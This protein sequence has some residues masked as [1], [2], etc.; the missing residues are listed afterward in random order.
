MKLKIVLTA[1]LSASLLACNKNELK[2][3]H[4]KSMDS[5]KE[6]LKNLKVINTE[7]PVCHMKTAGFL[8]DTAI[9]KNNTYGFC[10]IYCKDEFKRNP[11]K[12]VQK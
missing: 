10:S 7:D 3:K 8:R 12:Y 4:K 11:E 5:S 9:Y 1:L 6:N 2:V